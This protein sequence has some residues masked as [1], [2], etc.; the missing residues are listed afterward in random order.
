MSERI[1]ILY[2][3][4]MDGLVAC[5]AACRHLTNPAV[6]IDTFP[7]QYNTPLHPEFSARRWSSIYILDYALPP[8]DF[9]ALLERHMGPLVMLDHHKTSAEAYGAHWQVDGL[10]SNSNSASANPY[11][12][13]PDENTK[14]IFH[15][16]VAGCTMTEYY[17]QGQ[18]ND[19]PP[20]EIDIPKLVAYAADHD[21]WHFNLPSSKQIRTAFRSYPMT[22]ATCD[23]LN[24]FLQT[25]HGV[26]NLVQ[27]GAAIDRNNQKIISTAVRNAE[28]MHL[29][30]YTG[31]ATEMPVSGLISEVAGALAQ[32]PNSDFGCCWFKTRNTHNEH[33]W[34]Y[35][36]RSRDDKDADALG[37][38][39]VG[40][41]AKA[42]GGGGHTNAA[43]FESDLSPLHYLQA[44]E[45]IDKDDKN[46]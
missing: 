13:T 22:L 15:I 41:L 40:I 38:I 18:Y 7:V 43:G 10:G 26:Y 12:W 21:L 46:V 32:K 16:G 23:A 33:K 36:L 1:A 5:W 17:L 4:D 2:H 27:Q 30:G 31:L 37:P 14:V 29:D 3:N 35:S 28:K 42:R 9:D 20:K 34:V 8:Q 19:E 11:I 45:T 39:D 44:N 25:E 6:D 24:R